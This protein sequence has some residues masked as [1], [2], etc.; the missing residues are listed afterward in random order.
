VGYICGLSKFVFIMRFLIALLTIV[1]VACGPTQSPIDKDLSQL[2]KAYDLQPST[3]KAQAFLDKATEFIS[4]N[5][6][7]VELINPI[8]QKAA[9]FAIKAKM[10]SKASGFLIAQ[11]RNS[12]DEEQVKS[13][14]FEL[15][16]IMKDI[17]KSHASNIIFK[18][19]SSRFPN[20]PNAKE[21]TSLLTQ[22]IASEEGY[23]KYLFDQV[24]VDPEE[25]GIN[26]NN[27]LKFVDGAEAFAL[28][29]PANPEVPEYLYKAAEVARSLRT[30]PKAMSLYDWILE[31]YADHPKA[32]TTLFIKGFLLEQEF[33]QNDEARK[34]YE[35]FIS[36]YPEHEMASSAKFLLNNM[37]KSDEEIL[38]DIE[39]KRGADSES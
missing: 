19:L 9:D 38:Q 18:G 1:I 6:E 24:L 33:G 7:N 28:S 10:P 21:A 31:E 29:L 26:R 5:R 36:Q 22:E 20:D 8:I 16:K 39:S 17:N 11:V 27:A 13:S 30:M 12:S 25:F 35:Q 14:L 2:E 34:I 3:E 32:P 23:L 15:G 4:T 37:G